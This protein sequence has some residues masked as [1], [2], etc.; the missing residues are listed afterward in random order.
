MYI[1]PVIIV[2]ASVLGMLIEVNST[3]LQATPKKNISDVINPFY[4]RFD[5]DGSAFVIDHRSGGYVYHYDMDGNFITSFQ[6]GGYPCDIAFQEDYLFITDYSNNKVYKYTKSGQLLGTVL[7]PPGPLSIAIDCDGNFYI[8][9]WTGG[10]IN[11][12][13]SDFSFKREITGIGTYPRKIQ[14]DSND[15]IRVLS[16][17]AGA[18]YIYVFTKCGRL[19]KTIPA[20][21]EP[22]ADGL[23]VDSNDNM[24][25]S[26]RRDPGIGVH[27][28]N[29]DGSEV[30]QLTGYNGVAD[31]VVA[32]D[33]TLW[34]SDFVGGKIYLY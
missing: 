21:D 24:Y 19:V 11:V 13:G 4:I 15:H 22:N 27:I 18:V 17:Y 14:F 10:K 2:I 9:E 16:H 33:G 6:P 5:S 7:N 3:S 31:A 28:I 12:Y 32:P 26:V 30:L 34:V 1:S 23:F 8:G 20:F 29:N 25:M